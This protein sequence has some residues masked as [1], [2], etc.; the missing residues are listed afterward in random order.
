MLE[1]DLLSHASQTRRKELFR[2]AIATALFEYTEE[3]KKR[4]RET[5]GI[6]ETNLNSIL[7]KAYSE[8]IVKLN[9]T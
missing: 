7:V 8:A 2:Q 4:V 6:N 5:P 3:V 9:K 1:E